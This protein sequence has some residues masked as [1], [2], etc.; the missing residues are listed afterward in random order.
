MERLGEAISRI[1]PRLRARI[2]DGPSEPEP[3]PAC[4]IC[5]DYGFVRHDVPLG[6]ADFGR[7]IA[8]SCRQGEIRDR[9]ARRSH[10]GALTDRS[11]ET[12]LPVSYTHLRAH[13]TR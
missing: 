1:R 11:F 10:L 4:P 12:F 13:E 8:C 6:H 9:L 7:A 5:K 3:E 2:G